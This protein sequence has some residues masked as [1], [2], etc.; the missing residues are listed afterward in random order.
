VTA[1]NLHVLIFSFANTANV[2]PGSVLPLSLLGHRWS[3]AG[4]SASH[5]PLVPSG[6]AIPLCL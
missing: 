5:T 3:L 2:P 6:L 4:V 1:C